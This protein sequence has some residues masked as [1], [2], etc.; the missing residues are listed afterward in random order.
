MLDESIPLT[1]NEFDEWGN[2][3][4]P[5]YYQYMLSYSPYDQIK[6]KDYPAM[7]VGTGLW[8]SQVQYFEP[9]KYVARLR[10][11]KTDVMPL[12]L[13]TNMQAGHGGKMGRAS[14]RER[15]CKYV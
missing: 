7:F 5:T 1:T 4:D 13:R 9:A 11:R 14:G 6:R 15:V 2:P 8:D 3:S 12:L 10:A